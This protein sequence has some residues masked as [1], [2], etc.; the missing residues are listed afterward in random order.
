MTGKNFHN[1]NQQGPSKTLSDV[2]LTPKWIID[3]IG[4]FDL[5]PC[6][7][8]P[9]GVPIVETA[10]KYFTEEENGLDKE[11]HGMVF[12]NF[13]YSKSYDWLR[14]CKEEYEK[15]C[16][17]IIVLCFARTETRAWQHNVVS[18]TGINFINKRIKFLNHEGIEKG[19]GNAPSCLIAFGDNAFERIKKVDGLITKIC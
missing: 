1:A 19:N 13:P 18:A 15:G 8:K 7:W 12:V 11:W 9:S 14:K 10:S 2:W 5:D 17:E 6:G 3:A 4:P 16:C